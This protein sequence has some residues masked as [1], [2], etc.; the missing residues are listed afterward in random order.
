[1]TISNSVTQHMFNLNPKRRREKQGRR[2]IYRVKGWEFS[3]INEKQVT[4]SRNT[5]QNKYQENTAMN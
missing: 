1:M 4:D 2:N 5:K 3:T